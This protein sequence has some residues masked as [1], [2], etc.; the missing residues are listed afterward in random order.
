[1]NLRARLQDR[2]FPLVIL[3]SWIADAIPQRPPVSLWFR[4]TPLLSLCFFESKLI[5]FV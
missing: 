3:G 5:M 4:D 1:M 2:E